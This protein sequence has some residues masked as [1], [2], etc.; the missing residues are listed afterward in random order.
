[1]LVKGKRVLIWS[2]L[3]SSLYHLA[4]CLDNQPP[5]FSP[6]EFACRLRKKKV[7][8][9]TSQLKVLS[10]THVE[11]GVSSFILLANYLNLPF[12]PQYITFIVKPLLLRA[13]IR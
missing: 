9:M 13:F 10:R 1:V 8:V 2:I 7:I 5:F 12:S 6:S 3:L 4:T 11:E